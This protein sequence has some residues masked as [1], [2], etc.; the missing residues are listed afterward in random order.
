[1]VARGVFYG[2]NNLYHHDG[3]NFVC[4]PGQAWELLDSS[5]NDTYEMNGK[6]WDALWA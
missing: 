4:T 6:K 2:P 5:P 1:M 3:V